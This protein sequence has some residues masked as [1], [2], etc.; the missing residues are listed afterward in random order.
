MAHCQVG[1]DL[2]ARAMCS[3]E[4]YCGLGEWTLRSRLFCRPGSE[5]SRVSESRTRVQHLT[6]LDET[7]CPM[8]NKR[9]LKVCYRA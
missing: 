5:L 3:T 2:E 6:Q 1:D 4:L 9:T 8:I 7:H